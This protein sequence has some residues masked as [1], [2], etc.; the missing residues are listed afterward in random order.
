MDTNVD[1]D[2]IS[3]IDLIVMWFRHW[4]PATVLGVFT[5]FIG[6]I[7]V[8]TLKNTYDS[9]AR[10]HVG[11]LGNGIA[12]IDPHE[13]V[14]HLKFRFDVDNKNSVTRS[15]P[16]I[17]NVAYNK[18]KGEFV[19]KVVARGY[20]PNGVA[21]FLRDSLDSI[22]LEQR[23]SF[24]AYY[25]QTKTLYGELRESNSEAVPSVFMQL[26]S[27]KSP[28]ILTPPTVSSYPSGP[29]KL[30]YYVLVAMCGLFAALFLPYALDLFSRIRLAVENDKT[31]L[32]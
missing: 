26:K 29:K 31:K 3:L 6:C 19:I 17:E 11:Q 12:L 30:L 8:S 7:V 21:A 9:E 2:E 10:I 28:D 27:M 32:I 22:L 1:Y 18:N 24:D 13:M 20:E 16:R 23:N 15:F 25:K 14:A 4:V 5:I